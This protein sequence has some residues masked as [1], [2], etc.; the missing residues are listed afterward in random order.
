MVHICTIMGSTVEKNSKLSDW[1][2]LVGS[3]GKNGQSGARRFWQPPGLY[4]L[5]EYMHTIDDHECSTRSGNF[6]KKF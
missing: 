2:R 3:E 6:F 1:W 5:L 4:V